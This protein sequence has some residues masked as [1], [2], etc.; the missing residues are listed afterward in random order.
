M[1]VNRGWRVGTVQ[2]FAPYFVSVKSGGAANPG[3][4]VTQFP[5]AAP[6]VKGA[7]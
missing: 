6:A 4:V 3:A 7:G 1:F 5:A 2:L